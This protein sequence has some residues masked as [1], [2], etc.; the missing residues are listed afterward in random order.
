MGATI[1]EQKFNALTADEI[2]KG[3]ALFGSLRM[4]YMRYVATD[5]LPHM[6]TWS[7]LDTARK[8]I[9]CETAKSVRFI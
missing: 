3:Q 9:F 4:F 8:L 1:I 5:L 2:R 6:K 7:E